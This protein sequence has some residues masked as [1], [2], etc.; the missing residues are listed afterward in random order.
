MRS[1]YINYLR[2]IK[3]GY[4]GE[5]WQSKINRVYEGQY[6]RQI[7][8]ERELPK[9]F[10][11]RRIMYTRMLTSAKPGGKLEISL[12]MRRAP[13]SW[14]TILVIG[15]VKSTK[16]LYTK[17][18]DYEDALLEAWRRKTTS[19]STITVENLL[20]NL[21]RLGWE[22]PRAVPSRANQ[23]R[24]PGDRRVLMTVAEEG[25]PESHTEDT[26]VQEEPQAESHDDMLREVYQVMQKRQRAPPPGGYMF[27]RNDHVTTKMGRLPPSPCQACGSANHWDKE[28]PDWEV[29][30]V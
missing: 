25:E 2:G 21:K 4:L 10:V 29:Y 20:P 14:K 28:C 23:E 22:P 27:S 9:T 19:A 1:H 6:F 24:L 18:V 13:I 15:S 3:D 17:V 11:I 16:A 8:H 5:A 30:R 12:I 7:G 26:H